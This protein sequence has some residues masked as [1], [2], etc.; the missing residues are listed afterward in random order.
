MRFR[1]NCEIWTAAAWLPLFLFCGGPGRRLFTRLPL[2][3]IN[4]LRIAIL[5]LLCFDIHTNCR[6]CVSQLYVV[7]GTVLPPVQEGSVSES[8]SVSGRSS[9][10]KEWSSRRIMSAG[11]PTPGRHASAEVDILVSVYID[12][13][14]PA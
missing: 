14:G 11:Q 3:R 12:A 8:G 6:G 7:F 13:S 5:Q 9:R 1:Q 4:D 10:V 2:F